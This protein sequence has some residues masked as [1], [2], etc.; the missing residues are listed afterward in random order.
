MGAKKPRKI[1]E[2]KRAKKGAEKVDGL[3]PKDKAKIRTALRRVWAWSHPRKLALSRVVG[4]DGFSKC[5]QCKR[6]APKV[7]VDHIEP[8]GEVD[9]GFINRLFVP[10]DKLQILCPKCHRFKTNLQRR[11]KGF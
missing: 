1:G 5:E 8:V 7:H 4:E 2:K 11:F 9:E 6:V 3:G 10:S